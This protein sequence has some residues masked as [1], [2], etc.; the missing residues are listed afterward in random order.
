MVVGRGRHIY[1]VSKNKQIKIWHCQLGYTSNTRVIK[2]SGL[3][4]GINISNNI[5]Y[6]PKEVFIDTDLLDTNK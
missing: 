4:N 1:I 2:A 3:V 5:K 6:N